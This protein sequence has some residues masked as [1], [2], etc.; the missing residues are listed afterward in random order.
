MRSFQETSDKLAITLSVL[1]AIH[2]LALPL[3][4]VVLPSILAMPFAEESFHFWLMVIVVPVSVY[5]LTL[6]CKQHKRYRIVALGAVG[7]S[8]LIV[9]A[10]AGERYLTE[11]QEKIF[12]LIGVTIIALGHFWNFHLC[13]EKKMCSFSS[14]RNC[15]E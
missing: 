11:M 4:A 1:C 12:T 8:I 6:G 7:L 5:A 2:C 3:I 13:R 9:T 15:S 14:Q 10:I